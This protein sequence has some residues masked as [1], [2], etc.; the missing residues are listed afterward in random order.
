MGIDGLE[1]HCSHRQSPV[2]V[3]VAHQARLV[4]EALSLLL[5]QCP[6]VCIVP[7][8]PQARV[9]PTRDGVEVTLV[10]TS[11][12]VEATARSIRFFRE[13]FP[14]SRVIVVGSHDPP[15]HILRYIQAGASG[16]LSP[17]CSAEG[18]LETIQ[19]V[20]RGGAVC[21]PDVLA[22]LFQHIASTQG[23]PPGQRVASLDKLTR[24]EIEV[25][26]LVAAGRSNKEI[27]IAL[28]LEVQ[29]VKNHVHNILDKLQVRS[30]R[31]V[32]LYAR[33]LSSEG[34]AA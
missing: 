1:A 17:H 21:P 9:Q 24:R 18:L 20:S 5:R 23:Q 19:T 15:E 29:T 33:A 13:T 12:G 32:A 28:R 26:E 4:R 27:S 22:M 8:D 14:G 30:R 31:Q 2:R 3:L 6:D 34:L 25:L 7:L 11:A 16:Y 10:D